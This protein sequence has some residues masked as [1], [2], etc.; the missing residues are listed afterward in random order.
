MFGRLFLRYMPWW[1]FLPI[2]FVMVPLAI[3]TVK[4]YLA[5]RAG[6]DAAKSAPAPEVRPLSDFSLDPARTGAVEVA[7][8]G[9][10]KGF[11]RG[12]EAGKIDFAFALLEPLDGEG[13]TVALVSEGYLFD[14]LLERIAKA[15]VDGGASLIRGFEEKDHRFKSRI[16][17][18][19]KDAGQTRHVYVVEPYWGTR[20]AALDGRLG[21]NLLLVF[22]SVGF[23][24]IFALI[25]GTKLVRWI[26]RVR[27]KQGEVRLTDVDGEPNKKRSIPHTSAREE[28]RSDDDTPVMRRR[29]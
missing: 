8:L 14:L 13:A 9:Q 21:S 11:A 20:D 28:T 1:A 24:V 10:Y 4:D 23:T 27:A 25:S 26:L 3:S 15:K 22:V 6:L 19:L 29:R 2:L 5:L 12:I 18:A 7:V 17:R 16:E